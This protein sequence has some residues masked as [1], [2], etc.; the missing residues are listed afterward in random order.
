MKNQIIPTL[1]YC[2]GSIQLKLSVSGVDGPKFEKA[3]AERF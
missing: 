2:T 1:K 3:M